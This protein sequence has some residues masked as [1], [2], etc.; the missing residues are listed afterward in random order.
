MAI[1]FMSAL[2]SF[3]RQFTTTKAQLSQTSHSVKPTS[4]P[5]A[6]KWKIAQ[7]NHP[8]P[9]TNLVCINILYRYIETL[10]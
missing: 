4:D 7:E 8:F 6:N 2:P 9:F 5:T 10:L 3:N 1:H